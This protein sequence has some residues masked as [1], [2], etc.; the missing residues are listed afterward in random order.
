V[1]RHKT[2]EEEKMGFLQKLTALFSPSQFLT[3]ANGA[4]LAIS[5]AEER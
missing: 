1:A 5:N 3:E 4:L 2:E